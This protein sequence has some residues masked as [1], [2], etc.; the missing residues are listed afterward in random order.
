MNRRKFLKLTGI[1][2]LALIIPF[3]LAA[4]PKKKSLCGPINEAIQVYGGFEVEEYGNQEPLYANVQVSMD[5]DFND[6]FIVDANTGEPIV[7]PSSD[8]LPFSYKYVKG[9]Y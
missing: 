6:L 3:E 1:T 4:K 9:E 5:Y 7:L 8:P 2:A